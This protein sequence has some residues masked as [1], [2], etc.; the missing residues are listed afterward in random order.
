MQRY[1]IKQ[2]WRSM[3]ESDDG[4]FVRY[5]GVKQLLDDYKAQE[6]LMYEYY[7]E[8]QVRKWEERRKV[9]HLEVRV[10]VLYYIIMVMMGVVLSDLVIWSLGVL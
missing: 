7:K 2:I 5:E 4:E 8:E 10:R 3:K 6:Q 9:K 1:T